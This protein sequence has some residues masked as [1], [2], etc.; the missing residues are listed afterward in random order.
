[1]TVS[2]QLGALL[3]R[4]L[5]VYQIWGAN[6]D[7]GKTVFSTILCGLTSKYRP[8]EKTAFLKPVSTGPE[9]EA[10]DRYTRKVSSSGTGLIKLLLSH[11]ARFM[12]GVHSETL[13]QFDLPLSPH[14][15]AQ[16][17]QKNTP[18]DREILSGIHEFACSHASRSRAGWLFVETAG[19]VHSPGPSGTTQADL[20]RPLRLPAILVGDAKLGGISQTISAFESLKLRGYDVELILLFRNDAYQNHRYLASYFEEHGSIPVRTAP[21]PPHPPLFSATPNPG[22]VLESDADA[23]R[24]QAYYA[25]ALPSESLSSIP[26]LLASS[27]ANR[28]SRLESMP[29]AASRTIWYPFTQHQH[30]RPEEITVIDSAKD[31]HFDVTFTPSSSSS[32]ISSSSSA[33]EDKE[34]HPPPFLLGPSFDGSASWWTQGLGHGNPDLALEAAYA[35]GRYGHVMLAGAVHE[36][37]LALA[38]TLLSGMGNP[39]LRRVFYSDNGS[40]GVEVAVKMA[41]RASGRRYYGPRQ[42]GNNG[43]NN[44]LPA[45]G[46]IGLRGSYH[47]DT[48]GAMD[49]SEPGVFN[50]KVEWYEGKGVWLDAP[51]V[52]CERG[53]WV[54]SD[55]TNKRP[56]EGRRT[57]KFGTLGEVFDLEK[58][59]ARGEGKEYEKVIR[60]DLERLTLG[61]AASTTTR[62]GGSRRRFGALLLEPVVLGAGGMQLVDPLFQRTLVKVVRASPELFA[63]NHGHRS[64]DVDDELAWSGLPVVFDEVFTGI[65]RLGRFSA[66]SFLGVDPDISV[67]AKLLTGG[68]LPLSATLASE[69][70]FR[71]FLSDDKSDALLHGHSYTAHAVGCQVALESLRKLM[72]MERSGEWDWA[73]STKHTSHTSHDQ[74]CDV[75][76]SKQHVQVRSTVWSVWSPEL[77]EWLSWQREKGVEGVWALGT[78]LAI[79]MGCAGDSGGYKSTAAGG[80]QTALLRGSKNDG[81]VHSRVLGNVL[82]LMAGQTTT[83]ETVRRVERLIRRGLEDSTR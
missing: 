18:S 41:L 61:T 74:S 6:T 55:G 44:N 12:P 36:P 49:C 72:K 45:A 19:G 47:G 78:V 69:S 76:S 14:L 13:Y 51:A 2:R 28:I 10:D 8:H 30:L 60:R 11:I 57:E 50:E 54:V 59:E 48:M 21:L 43:N 24:M 4:S 22:E 56:G 20:Y 34:H 42:G 38:E 70:I 79:H 77:V 33:D 23:R 83:E 63:G 58:R 3:H 32:S 73:L 52:R 80:L 1:M 64:D 62:E 29:A 66:A 82:Y 9:Q 40:T 68:L 67:H 5:R 65:Y 39:R 15:A 16:A 17:S 7:V 71:S 37:A 53:A 46:V 26:A 31:S 81:S 25:A 27:S 35:A 75:T